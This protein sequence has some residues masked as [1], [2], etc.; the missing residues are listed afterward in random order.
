ML[1]DTLPTNHRSMWVLYVWLVHATDA[2]Q[3][4]TRHANQC[5][6]STFGSVD[7]TKHRSEH[8]QIYCA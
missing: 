6:Y 2:I 8:D 5:N 1:Q 4:N 7:R 3:N